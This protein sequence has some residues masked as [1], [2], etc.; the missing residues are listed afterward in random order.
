MVDGDKPPSSFRARL[1]NKVQELRHPGRFHASSPA[2]CSTSDVGRV[3]TSSEPKDTGPSEGPNQENPLVLAGTSR[4]SLQAPIV[5]PSPSRPQICTQS[6][7][8]SHTTPRVETIEPRSLW[9]EAFKA[10]NLEDQ[11]SCEALR[12]EPNNQEPFSARVNGLLSSTKQLQKKC[13]DKTYRFVFGKKTIV[14]RDTV[15]N[16]IKWLNKFKAVGDI[17]VQFDPVH[18]ALPWAGF[19]LLLQVCDCPMVT[20]H[21]HHSYCCSGSLLT[22]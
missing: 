9:A 6:E 13:E 14:M 2:D 22:R 4:A 8:G 17:I 5:D 21:I 20:R 19:R 16:V 15:G 10:L 3:S 7:D 11:K 1:K 18:A 12:A